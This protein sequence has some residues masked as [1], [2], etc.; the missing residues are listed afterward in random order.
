MLNTFQ[1]R[2][3]YPLNISFLKKRKILFFSKLRLENWF[4]KTEFEGQVNAEGCYGRSGAGFRQ[5]GQ[6]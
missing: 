1:K 5:L 2:S 3:L 6:R 4:K